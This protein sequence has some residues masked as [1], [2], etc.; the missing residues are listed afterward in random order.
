MRVSP[1][2]TDWRAR[3]PACIPRVHDGTL[4]K[5][6][7]PVRPVQILVVEDDPVQLTYIARGIEIIGHATV[8]AE[9]AETAI[10]LYIQH[11]CEVVLMDVSDYC[12]S[13]LLIL[14]MHRFACQTAQATLW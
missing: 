5:K 12:E 6:A 1:Q 11:Q 8:T 4:V 13:F 14:C 3:L 10:Q 2:R 7:A 9:N